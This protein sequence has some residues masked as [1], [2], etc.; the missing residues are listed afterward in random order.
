MKTPSQQTRTMDARSERI[1][2][3]AETLAALDNP[4]KRQA[5]HEIAANNLASWSARSPDEDGPL[6]VDVFPEDWGEVARRLTRE[7]GRCYAVLN[8]A[9][10]KYAGGGYES[11]AGAQEENMFRRTDCHYSLAGQTVDSESTRYLP[12]MSQLISGADGRVYLDTDRPR[13][14]LRGPEIPGDPSASY[15]WLDEGEIFPFFELRA[16]AQR[17][18]EG[19]AFSVAEARRRIEAQLDTLIEKGVRHAV[20][21]ASGCGAFNNPVDII[22]DLYHTAIQDRRAA[23]AHIAF[24]IYT[25]SD[26]RDNYEPFVRR[27]SI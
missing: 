15:R 10:A 20:L 26:G 7:R 22:A 23:F 27:L 5:Y 2:V 6:Q 3:L 17:H 9:N 8:M 11:G 21:G 1:R 25:S 14:C 16:A 24:A 13:V 18:R 4:A 19:K 12:E